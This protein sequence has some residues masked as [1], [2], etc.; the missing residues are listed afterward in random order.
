[1]HIQRDGM[2]VRGNDRSVCSLNR[3][4]EPPRLRDCVAAIDSQI[5]AGDVAARI[6]RQERHCSHE[7]LRL[8]HLALWDQ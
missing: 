8:A 6:A 1:M 4:E 5:R 2:S 7:V 3:C